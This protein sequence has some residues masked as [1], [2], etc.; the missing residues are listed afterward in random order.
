M[1]N[2]CNNP[3]NLSAVTNFPELMNGITGVEQVMEADGIMVGLSLLHILLG[4]PPYSF[5]QDSTI[6]PYAALE[7]NLVSNGIL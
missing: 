6:I 3:N 1:G 5:E 7:W 2:T 4:S